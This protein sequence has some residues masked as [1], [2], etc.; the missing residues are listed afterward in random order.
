MWRFSKRLCSIARHS[1]SHWTY[2]KHSTPVYYEQTQP[3]IDR[4]QTLTSM[5]LLELA[6]NNDLTLT[7][8][9]ETLRLIS[10]IG[11]PT[12]TQ[13]LNLIDGLPHP[14]WTTTLDKFD[15]YAEIDTKLS[16]NRLISTL[17]CKPEHVF[18]MTCQVR[19]E[20]KHPSREIYFSHW[21]CS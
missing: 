20:S 3:L 1:V 15:L 7:H 8:I 19:L 4:L 6:R 21:Q 11:D 16:F 13:A 14:S 9:V 5:S 17:N 10:D 12:V 18:C 2:T